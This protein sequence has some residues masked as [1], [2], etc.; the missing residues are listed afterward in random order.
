MLALEI[1]E[2][3]QHEA[4][5]AVFDV[6]DVEGDQLYKARDRSIPFRIRIDDEHTEYKH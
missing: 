3:G 2:V 5:Y 4:D 1:E 6:E